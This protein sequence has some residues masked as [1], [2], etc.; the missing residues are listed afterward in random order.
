MELIMIKKIISATV[1]LLTAIT[2]VAGEYSLSPEKFSSFYAKNATFQN[3]IFEGIPDNGGAAL[4]AKIPADFP[5]ENNFRSLIVEITNC[6]AR[7]LSVSFRGKTQMQIKAVPGNKPDEYFFNFEK[8][9]AELK[10]QC[11]KNIVS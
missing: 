11:V 9:P 4:V 2:A 7:Q 6:D 1:C 3:G 5:K 10:Q 8:L